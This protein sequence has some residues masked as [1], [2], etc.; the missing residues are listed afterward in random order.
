MKMIEKY[1]LELTI[2]LI[3][4]IILGVAFSILIE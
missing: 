3:Y 1:R 4:S 2:L